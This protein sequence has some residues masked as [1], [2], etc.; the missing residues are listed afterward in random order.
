MKIP[1]PGEDFYHRCSDFLGRLQQA[2]GFQEVKQLWS[3]TQIAYRMPELDPLSPEYREVVLAIY[4][5]LTQK[6]YSTSNELTSTKQSAETFQI[7]YPWVSKDCGVAAAELAK[8]VQALSVLAKFSEPVH[9][10]IE[11][12][13]GWANL[14][15]P[16]AKLGLD[17][18]AVDIDRAFLDRAEGLVERDGFKIKTYWGDFVEVAE[19]LPCTYDVA[20]FQSSF[21][22]C[23]EFDAL[24]NSLA[25]HVLSENG[26]ILFLAEP[27]YHGYAFPWGLRYDGES[28]WAIMCNQWLELGFDEDFFTELL[29]RHG[30]FTS[31]VDS[32]PGLVGDGW[33][34]TRFQRGIA[35]AA[36]VLPSR[37]S[38][39]FWDRSA[40]VAHG[41][42][43]RDESHL[44]PLPP[45]SH[46][47]LTLQNFCQKSLQ[48]RIQG[49]GDQAVLITVPPQSGHEI[50]APISHRQPLQLSCETVVPDQLSQNGDRRQIGLALLQLAII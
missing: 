22:H 34:A 16:L 20:I 33:M 11:F 21:H 1:Q 39:S 48:L 31:R 38:R 49:D 14:A 50:E 12:G 46:Y 40:E 10:V 45:S 43:L 9:S 41:R 5:R 8:T 2:S 26:H 36:C 28:L 19:R 32:L 7:G 37:F 47:R 29:W 4:Q 13:C 27:I 42:F 3:S 44:P 24:M 18:A 30:F 25:A 35:F 17:V 6:D 23:L 15:L